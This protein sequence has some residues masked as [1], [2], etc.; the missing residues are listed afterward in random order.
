MTARFL[1]I[2]QLAGVARI[3][4]L[5]LT[6]VCIA[7]AATAS[8]QS[9]HAVQPAKLILV[10]GLGLCAH[11]S[12]NAFNEYFDF[13]SG[14]DLLTQRT[15]FS[16][17]SGTLVTHPQASPATLRLAVICLAMLIM[18][19]LYLSYELGWQALL[20]GVPGVL[21][22]FGYTQYIN[23]WP[24][25]CLLAPGVGFGMLMT[26]GAYWVF[27]GSLSHTAWVHALIVTL[28]VSNLLLLN[29]FPDAAADRQAGR[30]HLPIS[31]G[32]P[33]SARVFL[34]LMLFSYLV[35]LAAVLMGPLA[36]QS[37]LA[38][39]TIPWS[40]KLAVGVL[41]YADNTAALTPYLGLNVLFCHLYLLLM[42]AGLLWAG[43]LTG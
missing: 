16:G 7:L 33:K 26:L 15:P 31:I 41:R 25:L 38:L 3:N 43:Q 6:L 40:V 5:T 37:L 13:Q 18:G 39:V 30:R 27:A 42:L 29:Q 22:I 4:F 9:G 21:L 2:K 19:G 10:L 34:L 32:R 36:A 1:L 24:L 23:Q 8:W 11:I 14:L 35:L 17:G 20:I 12:V 28:L